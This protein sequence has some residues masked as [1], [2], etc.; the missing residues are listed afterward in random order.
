MHVHFLHWLISTGLLL[1]SAFLTI[2]SMTG[3][4]APMEGSNLALSAHI[5]LGLV[6]E[7]WLFVG[8]CGH[9]SH[10]KFY[11]C[12]ILLLC[13]SL[14]HHPPHPRTPPTHPLIYTGPKLMNPMKKIHHYIS[15]CQ[16]SCIKANR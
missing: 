1:Q 7:Y 14:C 2:K 6:V 3:E 9:H 11:H 15:T 10:S 8:A 5:C 12:V 4:M 13:F 16:V